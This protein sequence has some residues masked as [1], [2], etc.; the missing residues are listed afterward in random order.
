MQSE[1][2]LGRSTTLYCESEENKCPGNDGQNSEVS[3]PFQEDVLEFIS[4]VSEEALAT[5][6][7]PVPRTDISNNEG[8]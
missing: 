5:E 8:R 1:C 3:K 6:K 2:L 4:K 7:R